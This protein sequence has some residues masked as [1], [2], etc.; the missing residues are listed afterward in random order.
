VLFALSSKILSLFVYLFKGSAEMLRNDM[1][2]ERCDMRVRLG[3]KY[4]YVLS[5]Y[6]SLATTSHD[7]TSSFQR[8]S[9]EALSSMF[10]GSKLN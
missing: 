6:H 3:A 10:L 1:T 5:C 2:G 4:G 9:Q 7:T 8:V